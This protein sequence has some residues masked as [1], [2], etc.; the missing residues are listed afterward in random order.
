MR[1]GRLRRGM[2][3]PDDEQVIKDAQEG[4]SVL[5]TWDRVLRKAAGGLTP[6][7]ALDKAKAEGGGTPEAQAK[8]S[9]L[10]GLSPPNLTVMC[11]SADKT[12]E[13]FRQKI[14][15]NEMGAKMIRLLGVE[16][17]YS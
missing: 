16:E 12:Y 4:G 7:E 11:D 3:D 9:R 14:E 5:V 1:I 6:F 10:H 8:V 2:L 15:F 17:E 13:L